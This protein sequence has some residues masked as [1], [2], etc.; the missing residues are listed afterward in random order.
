MRS[1]S[2]NSG[3]TD[4]TMS[5][6]WMVV[7][8]NDLLG[9]RLEPDLR[10]ASQLQQMDDTPRMRSPHCRRTVPKRRLRR[11]TNDSAGNRCVVLRA[12]VQGR[13]P[14][15]QPPSLDPPTRSQA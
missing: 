13:G 6:D 14:D 9:V 3:S 10:G 1:A 7:V 15:W 5:V 2:V 12:R 4:T 11:G 8:M